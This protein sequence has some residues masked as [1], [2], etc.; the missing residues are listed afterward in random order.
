[1]RWDQPIKPPKDEEGIS[2]IIFRIKHLEHYDVDIDN[3]ERHI[4]GLT[5]TRKVLARAIYRRNERVMGSEEVAQIQ[6]WAR[7]EE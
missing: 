3:L 7:G 5:E 2:E 4:A 1:M 6:A